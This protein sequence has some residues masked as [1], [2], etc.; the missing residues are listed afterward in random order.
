MGFNAE[1][2]LAEERGGSIDFDRAPGQEPCARRSRAEVE[3]VARLTKEH[4]TQPRQERRLVRR[5]VKRPAAD[6]KRRDPLGESIHIRVVAD[7]KIVVKRT[8][9]LRQLVALEIR[10][11]EVHQV[12]LQRHAAPAEPIPVRHGERVR[13]HKEVVFIILENPGSGGLIRIEDAAIHEHVSAV[14]NVAYPAQIASVERRARRYAGRKR[15]IAQG[16]RRRHRHGTEGRLADVRAV[17]R[18]LLRQPPTFSRVN[19]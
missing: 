10:D 12:G 2:K 14:K 6:S 8:Q 3:P 5:L 9:R 17:R 11:K 19:C 16:D 15:A 7:G 13:R 4:E 18:R 1:A